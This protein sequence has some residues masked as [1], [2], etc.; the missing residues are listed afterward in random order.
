MGALRNLIGT[1]SKK[2][3]QNPAR[4]REALRPRRWRQF[5]QVAVFYR[6][7]GN[8]WQA[9]PSDGSFERRVYPSYQDYLRRQQAK[10]EYLDL[11]RYETEYQRLLSERLAGAGGLR[12]GA[13]G[14]CLGRRRGAEA[15]ASQ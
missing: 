9:E 1:E 6:R 15:R 7:T 10:L 13:A 12:E 8:R 3:F 2:L 4:W 11:S 5:L 14:L